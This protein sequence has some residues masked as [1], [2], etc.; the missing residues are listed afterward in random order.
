MEQQKEKISTALT[1]KNRSMLNI[2]GISDIINSDENAVYL[3]TLDGALLIEGSELH[4]I[5]MNV[6]SGEITL[7]GRVDTLSYHDK[8][9]E[10][11]SG[12]FARMFK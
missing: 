6:G 5:S 4:I 8:S 7:E 10:T 12:F 1:L 2:D 9:Q 11:K 3:N